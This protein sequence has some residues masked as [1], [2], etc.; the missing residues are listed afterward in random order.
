MRQCTETV[1]LALIPF[2]AGPLDQVEPYLRRMATEAYEVVEENE[3][4]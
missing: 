1:G 3:T 4:R 2:V